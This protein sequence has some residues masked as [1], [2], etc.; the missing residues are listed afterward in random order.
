MIIVWILLSLAALYAF[1]IAPRL[2]RRPLG[3]LAGWDYAHRGLWNGTLP[4]NSLSA[5]RNAVSHG[6]GMEMDVHITRD[7]QLVVFIL[8]KR[9]QISYRISLHTFCFYVSYPVKPFLSSCRL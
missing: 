4:E 6:F 3:D 7:D 8:N 9:I 2:P 1:L 5:F